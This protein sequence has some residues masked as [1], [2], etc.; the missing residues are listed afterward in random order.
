[1]P[2]SR[3]WSRLFCRWFGH[4]TTGMGPPYGHA[5]YGCGRCGRL[6]TFAGVPKGRFR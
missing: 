1:V 4:S 3:P 6:V 5:T 2:V